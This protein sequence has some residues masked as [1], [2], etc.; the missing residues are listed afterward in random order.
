MLLLSIDTSIRGCSVAVHS[1]TGLLAAYDLFTDKSSSAMLT[2][3][4]RDSVTHAGFGL[5]DIDAIVVAKGP[6]SYTGLRVGVSTAKGL[7]YALEKP[8]IAINTLQAMALQLAP[9]YPGHLFCP[10]IDAR[11]MEVYAAV[12]DENNAFVQETQ[13]V[14]MNETSFE[15]LLAKRQVVFFGDGAAKCKPILEKHSNAVF[16]AI[17]IKPSARTVGQLGTIAFQN[18]QFEDVASFEPYYLKDFMSPAPRKA[19][20]LVQ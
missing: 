11:R 16:P 7:C 14:I 9:F 20:T 8:L 3:L 17:D 2:T 18:G 12:L 4:M 6:G 15:D 13:A 19:S 5:S 1:D 10:M